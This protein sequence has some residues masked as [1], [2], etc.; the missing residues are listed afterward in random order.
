MWIYVVAMKVMKYFKQRWYKG[1]S[2]RSRSASI[3]GVHCCKEHAHA[4]RN[5]HIYNHMA[6]KMELPFFF[7]QDFKFI[8]VSNVLYTLLLRTENR[9]IYHAVVKPALN[10]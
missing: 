10:L 8:E 1:K 9:S 3:S 2:Y 7:F 5:Y 4:L 6:A